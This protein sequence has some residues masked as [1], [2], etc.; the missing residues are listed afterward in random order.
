MLSSMQRLAIARAIYTD[1]PILLLDEATSALDEITE[2]KLLENLRRMTEKT[3]ILVTH[4]KTALSICD[5]VYSLAD[6]ILI[7]Q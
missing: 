6:G 3:V 5:T 1:A 7:S 4:R 2:E